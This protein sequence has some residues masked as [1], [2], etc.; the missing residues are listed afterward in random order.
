MTEIDDRWEK[1]VALSKKK[2]QATSRSCKGV[3]MSD[4]MDKYKQT[5][6]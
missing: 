5:S 6:S 4:N 3:F 2:K 1:V